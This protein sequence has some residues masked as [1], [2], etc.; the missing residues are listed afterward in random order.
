M[1]ACSISV[2]LCHLGFLTCKDGGPEPVLRDFK[3]AACWFTQIHRRISVKWTWSQLVQ[4]SFCVFE[5]G[6][7]DL[8]VSIVIPLIICIIILLLG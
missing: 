2:S 3:R 7:L 8:D 1:K 5:Q 6:P 4:A